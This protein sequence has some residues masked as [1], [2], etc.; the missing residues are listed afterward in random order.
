M[1]TCTL[2]YANSSGLTI[3][4]LNGL[5][6]S[7]AWTYGWSSH[8]INNTTLKYMDYSIGGAFT[9]STGSPT[10]GEMRMYAYAMLDDSTWPNIFSSGTAGTE[11]T[12]NV[13]DTEQLAASLIL[14]WSAATDTS[15]NDTYVMPPRSILSSFGFVPSK[16]ALFFTQSTVL[17]LNTSGNSVVAKGMYYNIA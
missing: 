4:N 16:F 2:E 15:A 6:S 7:S 9:V 11:G 5:G 8:T 13:T 12:I 3:T 1:A 10:A 14:L 17:N